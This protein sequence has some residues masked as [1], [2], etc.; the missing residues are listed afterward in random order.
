MFTF[1]Y[2]IAQYFNYDITCIFLY[3]L[4]NI[5]FVIDNSYGSLRFFYYDFGK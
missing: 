5:F 4:N 3:K 2:Y 1:S